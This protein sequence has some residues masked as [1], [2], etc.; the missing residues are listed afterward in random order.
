MFYHLSRRVILRLAKKDCEE[1]TEVA[2]SEEEEI[3]WSRFF[4]KMCGGGY[5][6]QPKTLDEN[7]SFILRHLESFSFCSVT[8]D[9]LSSWNPCQKNVSVSFF[10]L[11]LCLVVIFDGNLYPLQFC[12]LINLNEKN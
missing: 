4:E 2:I 5:F 11:V 8:V 3:F 12:F 6:W 10:L 1:I 9:H 7:F